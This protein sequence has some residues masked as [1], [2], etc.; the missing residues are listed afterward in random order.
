MDLQLLNE[1]LIELERLFIFADTTSL[2][3]RHLLFGSAFGQTNTAVPFPLLSNLLVGLEKDSPT[4]LHDASK[5]YWLKVKQQLQLTTRT[6][7]G[8]DGLL[9]KA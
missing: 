1:K 8:L 9:G 3:S 7:Q 6:L 5:A 4:E 2:P